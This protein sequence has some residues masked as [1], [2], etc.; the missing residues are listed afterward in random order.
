MSTVLTR[1]MALLVALVVLSLSSAP[2]AWAGAGNGSGQGSAN[3][4]NG[5]VTA[6]VSYEAGAAGSGGGAS[7]CFWRMPDSQSQAVP[8]VGV[9]QWPIVVGSVTYD[10]WEEVCPEG[11]TFF[12]A[13]RV[14]AQDLL[15]DLLRQLRERAI[16]A[17]TPTFHLLDER[18]GWAY[19]RTPLDFRAGSAW[20]PVSVTAAVGPVW[21]TV[22]ATPQRLTFDSGDPAGAG[23][24]TCA[25]NGPTAPY[26][27][28]A[29]G[30]CSYT[31][32]NA[33]STSPFDGYHFETAM[34]I[35]WAVSWSS[36]TGAGGVL[37]SYSTSAV[38]LL[39]VAEVKALVTCTGP[40]PL[41]GAC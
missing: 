37:E 12:A 28:E 23:P 36:S 29:P 2:A 4:A 40:R 22:T 6:T 31:Y 14:Q 20:Q 41:Q 9:G 27:A 24:V 34:T 18:F 32:E 1:A 35:E 3:Q 17:P 39:A 21:A 11:S 30:A 25:G 5:V 19:V 33:S 16:P 8:N 15:P 13:P 38:S 10:L 7:R 26:V